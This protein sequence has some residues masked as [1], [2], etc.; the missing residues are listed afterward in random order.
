MLFMDK[1]ESP[2][3]NFFRKLFDPR[4]S[5]TPP[6]ILQPTVP[7]SPPPPVGTSY[8]RSDQT[9]LIQLQEANKY[10]YLIEEASRRYYFQPSIICGIISR[11]SAW[12]I[13][14]KPPGPSGTGDF[15]QRI[16]RGQRQTVL[17]PDGKGYGRGLMQIDYDWHEFAR[18][19]NWQ[20]PQAN[21][22]YGCETLVQA[23]EFF[24]KR[25]PYLRGEQE[26]R[27]VIAAYNAGATATVEVIQK[28]EDIDT[29][30]TG[31]DYSKNVLDR[32][33]WFRLYG[34]A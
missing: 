16:P 27:A 17:P 21:I 26:L 11:E 3:F 2:V 8:Q 34:W 1:P 6:L 9:L 30:T 4:K 32:A 13:T 7:P 12:S 18:T 33:G 15:H 14:L 5:P 24:N 25:L 22:F 31:K 10:R 20:D 23:R 19:G 29:A 28:G